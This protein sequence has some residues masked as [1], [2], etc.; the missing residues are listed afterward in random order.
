MTDEE[1]SSSLSPRSAQRE[2]AAAAT[3]S[4]GSFARRSGRSKAPVSSRDFAAIA[5]ADTP[6]AYTRLF[7]KV[8]ALEVTTT[9]AD[10]HLHYGAGEPMPLYLLEK[11]HW[12]SF[13]ELYPRMRDAGLLPKVPPQPL[14]NDH[15]S[16][17]SAMRIL[18]YFQEHHAEFSQ[19]PR[20]RDADGGDYRA[21][22]NW[23][24]VLLKGRP[25]IIT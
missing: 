19:I 7:S 14:R 8:A 24:T 25:Y 15:P 23:T 10:P 13:E 5:A 20:I 6:P 1:D 18:L 2:A 21:P 11:F 9:M 16:L 17:S 4:A 22:A 12:I 3:S